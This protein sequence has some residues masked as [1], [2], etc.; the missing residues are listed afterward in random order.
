MSINKHMLKYS[1][2]G[3]HAT[4]SNNGEGEMARNGLKLNHKAAKIYNV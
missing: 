1:F 3:V 4:S 2:G